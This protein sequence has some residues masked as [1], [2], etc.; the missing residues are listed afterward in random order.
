MYKLL[1]SAGLALL[2]LIPFSAQATIMELSGDGNYSGSVEGDNNWLNSN[3]FPNGVDFWTFEAT[4][5]GTLAV[6]I[7]SDIDFGISVYAG[8]IMEDFTALFFDNSGDFTDG[9]L[10]YVDGTPAIPLPGSSLSNVALLSSGFFTIAVGGD[11]GLNM[12]GVFDYVM[13]VTT[14][15]EPAT[16]PEPSSLALAAVGGLALWVR[17][18]TNRSA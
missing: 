2:I 14:A 10:T 15:S 8:K 12:D 13:N 18:R 7:E 6:D 5:P 1:K 16:V 3:A 9:S 17:R 4:T 11:N